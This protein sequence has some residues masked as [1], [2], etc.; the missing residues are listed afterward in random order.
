[1]TVTRTQGRSPGKTMAVTDPTLTVT[2]L[3]RGPGP[4]GGPG[5]GPG[6]VQPTGSAMQFEMSA[7]SEVVEA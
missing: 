4:G 7:D 5:L 6:R 1:M 2:V 3:D